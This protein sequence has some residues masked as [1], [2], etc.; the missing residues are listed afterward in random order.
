MR[1][2]LIL[3]VLC[4]VL[5]SGCDSGGPQRM[6]VAGTIR[7]SGD[8]WYVLDSGNH[9]PIGIDRIEVANGNIRV[10]FTFTATDVHTFCVTPDDR[11]ASLGYLLG[12]SVGTQ[13]ATIKVSRIVEGS[14]KAV[15]ASEM[16]D[17][18]GN[19]WIYG[20]FSVE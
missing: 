19:I 17:P 5:C 11:Y 1:L 16:A 2:L 4:L 15:D 3:V 18:I 14:V 9:T 6:E 12:P 13:V 10:W 8:G 20:L 7:N